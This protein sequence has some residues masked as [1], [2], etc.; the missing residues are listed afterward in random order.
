MKLMAAV[1][2]NEVLPGLPLGR[3]L[4]VLSGPY[5]GGRLALWAHFPLEMLLIRVLE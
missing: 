2:I 3:W 1:S 5:R 4:S